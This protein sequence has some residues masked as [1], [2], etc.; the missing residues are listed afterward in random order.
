MFRR[1]LLAIL[2]LSPLALSAQKPSIGY[3]EPCQHELEYSNW[4]LVKFGD[5]PTKDLEP[6]K[7]CKKCKAVFMTSE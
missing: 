1:N 3:A 5:D 6:V 4:A 2:G 7:R